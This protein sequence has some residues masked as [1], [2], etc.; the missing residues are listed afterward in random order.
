MKSWKIFIKYGPMPI[1]RGLWQ[2][3]KLR[4]Y[5]KERYMKSEG[6]CLS[7]EG[8][9]AIGNGDCCPVCM[10]NGNVELRSD[11][12]KRKDEHIFCQNVVDR[13]FCCSNEQELEI[14]ISSKFP[15][16]I[17]RRDPVF[18]GIFDVFN[19]PDERVGEFV[20]YRMNVLPDLLERKSIPL[21]T[22]I[23]HGV[24]DSEKYYW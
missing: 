12:E 13:V 9:G 5:S 8:S 2:R 11:I 17:V 18:K 22:L 16:V 10:G 14:L 20:E 15:G 24:S 19:I 23:P 21:V 3:F 1:L 7:C 6:I 4:F